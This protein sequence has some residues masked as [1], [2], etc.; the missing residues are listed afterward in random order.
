MADLTYFNGRPFTRVEEGEDGEWTIVLDGDGRIVNKDP[1]RVMPEQGDLAG[2]Q[3]LRTIYSELDTRLQ[4]GVQENVTSEVVLTPALYTISDPN[5]TPEGEIFP[6]APQTYEE[7][8][9][10]DPSADRVVDGPENPDEGVM[11]MREDP[12]PTPEPDEPTPDEP[13]PDD[14]GE[15]D[16]APA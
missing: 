16:Q 14:G 9:P 6:Q 2:M 3:L 5:Y 1:E 13:T 8:I 12:T 10:P 11:S 15:G 4:F 7:E